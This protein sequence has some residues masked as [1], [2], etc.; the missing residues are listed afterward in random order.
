MVC[1]RRAIYQGTISV[2]L[3]QHWLLFYFSLIIA[4]LVDVSGNS[5]WFWFV[6]P[7]WLI[8]PNVCL[9]MYLYIFFGE[10]SSHSFTVFKMSCLPFMA[11]TFKSSFDIL[12]TWLLYIFHKY[13]FL[14]YML[15]YFPVMYECFCFW[16]SSVFLF[17][18]CCCMWF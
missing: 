13:H 6:F 4:I 12:D 7:Q 14:F 9:S 8:I 1:F 17:F 5:L 16:R 3:Y 15:S 11:F 2:N 10:I 18:F